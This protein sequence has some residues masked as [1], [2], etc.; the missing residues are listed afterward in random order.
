MEITY[1]GHSSFRLKGKT[2][3]VITDPYDKSVG[4]NF[5]K[6]SADMVTISHEHSDHNQGSLVD[7]VKKVI[8]GP[9]EYE[10]SGVSI[11]GMSTFHDD[12]KGEE[13]GENTIYIYEIDGVRLCH[14]G[15]L[16]HKLSD[17]KIEKVGSLDVLFIPVG[18]VLTIDSKKAAQLASDMEP[19]FIVPMHYKT[20]GLDEKTFGGLEEVQS[21]V[22]EAGLPHEEMGKLNVKKSLIDEDKKIIILKKK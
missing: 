5:P 13:R 15:D 19:R 2:A 9:G 10:I 1:L 7:G 8:N 20:K 21:F 6:V 22:T 14:L 12:K 11:I 18:G 17:K 4:F 3:T 16:G